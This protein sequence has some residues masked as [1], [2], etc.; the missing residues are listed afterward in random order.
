MLDDVS[1]QA[2]VDDINNSQHNIEVSS[3]CG[4]KVAYLNARSIPA[5]ISDLNYLIDYDYDVVM[6]S[7]TWIFWQCWF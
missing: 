1:M 4:I 2:L 3:P 7:E 5:H 6:I